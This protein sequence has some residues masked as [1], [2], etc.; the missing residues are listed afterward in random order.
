M[1][2]AVVPNRVE[3]DKETADFFEKP[4]AFRMTASDKCPPSAIMRQIEVV[5]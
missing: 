2:Y 5:R 3:G 1:E 4:T